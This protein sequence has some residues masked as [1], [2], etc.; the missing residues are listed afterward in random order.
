MP[1][2][3][4]Q[5]EGDFQKDLCYIWRQLC[6]LTSKGFHA[7]AQFGA[8]SIPNSKLKRIDAQVIQRMFCICPTDV[9]LRFEY[10][11]QYHLL[12]MFWRISITLLRRHNLEVQTCNLH[13]NCF[14]AW[15]KNISDLAAFDHRQI[16]C[17]HSNF[18]SS[19][20]ATL[21]NYSFLGVLGPYNCYS[22]NNSIVLNNRWPTINAEPN[23]K[24]W[25][26]QFFS[27]S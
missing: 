2:T 14:L 24:M 1:R 11:P 25:S 16:I 27:S 10:H 26:S 15:L 13:E 9:L 19:I 22:R 7:N 8:P 12:G 17:D 23:W 18:Q 5:H 4:W 20:R 21:V 3:T 6:T